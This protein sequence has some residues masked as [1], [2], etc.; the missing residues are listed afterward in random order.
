MEDIYTFYSQQRKPFIIVL[1]GTML[2]VGCLISIR[3]SIL[4]SI[5]SGISSI[6]FF[7]Y[8]K[9]LKIDFINKKYMHFTSYGPQLFGKWISIPD[10]KYISV[11]R[12]KFNAKIIFASMSFSRNVYIYQVNLITSNRKR[13]TVFEADTANESLTFAEKL[14]GKM[15][16]KIYD[17]T[18]RIGKFLDDKNRAE[19]VKITNI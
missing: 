9:G 3:K 16:L 2:I 6:G 17:A 4:F 14:S 1:I 8:K 5:I 7:S 13:I 11:F 19:N 18:Q 10:I 15:N 12:A